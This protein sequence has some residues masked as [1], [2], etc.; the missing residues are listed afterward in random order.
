MAG[1]TIDDDK[2][3]RWSEF[4]ISRDF[5]GPICGEANR[6]R[7]RYCWSLAKSFLDIPQPPISLPRLNS[8]LSVW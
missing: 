3:Q 1:D 2:W 8:S 7:I 6:R 5:K 4:R